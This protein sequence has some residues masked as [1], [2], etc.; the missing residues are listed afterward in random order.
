MKKKSK[1]QLRFEEFQDELDLAALKNFSVE[2]MM[3]HFNPD[4]LDAIR[5]P[6]SEWIFEK[7]RVVVRYHKPK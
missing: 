2:E 7:D 5:D 3:S 1:T 4:V 6:D